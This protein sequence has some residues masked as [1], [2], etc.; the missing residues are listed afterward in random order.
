V[1]K[2]LCKYSHPISNIGDEVMEILLRSTECFLFSMLGHKAKFFSSVGKLSAK[3][4]KG[5]HRLVYSSGAVTSCIILVL[6]F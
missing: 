4:R 1:D 6:V 5:V 2:V 3:R